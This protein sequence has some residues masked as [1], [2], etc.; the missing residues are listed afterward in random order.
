LANSST[1]AKRHRQ[2]IKRRIRNRM[3]KS[4]LRTNTRRLL[5]LVESQSTEDAKKQYVSVANLL[6]RAVSKGVLHRNTAARKKHRLHKVL[7]GT[8]K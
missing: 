1:A 6:D 7:A 8:E 5:E 3:V 4:E 2:N